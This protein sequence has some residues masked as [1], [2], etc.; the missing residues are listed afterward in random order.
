MIQQA[1][2][3]LV[4]KRQNLTVDQAAEAMRAIMSGE[5]TQAQVGAFL[6]ALRMKGETAEELAG[7]AS[8]MRRHALKVACASEVID[9]CG[10]GGALPDTYNASTTSAIIAAAAGAKVA[11]HGNVGAT[12]KS[13]S[14]DVLEA[15]GSKAKLTPE[16]VV[17][18][19]DEVGFG[20]MHAQAYHPSMKYVAP[21]RKEMG[22]RTVFNL[23][24]PLTNPAGASAQ[25]LGAPSQEA[26]AKLAAALAML[27]AK[28][29]MVVHGT[30]GLDEIS[31]SAETQVWEVA[32]G[33]V[34]EATIAP[35]DAGLERAPRAAVR[36]GEPA[37]NAETMR[38][39]F[40][41]QQGPMRDFVLL[42]AGA[43]MMVAGL[44]GDLR[45]GVTLAARAVDSG[46]ALDTLERYIALT[47]S[48]D[49]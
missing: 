43:A 11:K 22:V 1:L 18:C 4:N 49:E 5:A 28:H 44:A 46:A 33:E 30:D 25:V 31:I 20:F 21:V 35:E 47:R 45:E 36:G 12:S 23:L 16:Q 38:R 7:L 34:R 32:G 27:G 2:D 40:T 15:L 9:T 48:F 39:I 26:G 41:G 10:T 14:A 13:G 3:I 29:A 8:E 17:R 37:T 24:G 19:V 6:A 42:N